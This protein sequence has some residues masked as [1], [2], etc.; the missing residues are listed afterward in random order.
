MGGGRIEEAFSPHLRKGIGRLARRLRTF[1][2]LSGGI[3]CK[4]FSEGKAYF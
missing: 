4:F 2:L 1:F 3:T